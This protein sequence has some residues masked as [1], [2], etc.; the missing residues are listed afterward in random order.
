MRVT[1][2]STAE[3]GY[4]AQSEYLAE[5][6]PVPV[7]ESESES[8]TETSDANIVVPFAGQTIVSEENNSISV[9]SIDVAQ[10]RHN[11]PNIPN[12][13]MFTSPHADLSEGAIVA[14]HRPKRSPQFNVNDKV[15]KKAFAKK[16]M[17]EISEGENAF[18]YAQPVI[19]KNVHLTA[20][21]HITVADQ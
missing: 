17:Y 20:N 5:E 11:L 16:I 7:T 8:A 9:D 13:A 18:I 14:S 1:Y 4:A 21:T 3:D 6:F 19:N 12:E 10:Y 15:I 2:V